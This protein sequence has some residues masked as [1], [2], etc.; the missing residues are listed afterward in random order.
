M[1]F[2]PALSFLAGWLLARGLSSTPGTSRAPA[3]QLPPPGP[4]P[5]PAS[6]AGPGANTPPVEITSPV[7]LIP[8]LRYRAEVSLSWG[9]SLLASSSRVA[10]YA[11]EQGF[12]MVHVSTARPSDWPGAGSS[13]VSYYVDGIYTSAPRTMDLPSQISRAWVS[14]GA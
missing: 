4:L 8:G 10:S 14:A 5:F 11:A 1:I 12:S 2:V 9:V 7:Y 3:A 13:G 6:P